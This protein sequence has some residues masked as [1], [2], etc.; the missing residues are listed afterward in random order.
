VLASLSTE[1]Y[2]VSKR[3]PRNDPRFIQVTEF[4]TDGRYVHDGVTYISGAVAHDQFGVSEV[5]P[6][7][8]RERD[9]PRLGRPYRWVCLFITDEEAARMLGL[10]PHQLRDRRGGRYFYAEPDLASTHGPVSYP[11][12]W[13]DPRDGSEWLTRAANPVTWPRL[14]RL[15]KEVTSETQADKVPG[16]VRAKQVSLLRPTKNSDRAWL[17]TVWVYHKEDSNEHAKPDY[18]VALKAAD[19]QQAIY[20][21]H[22]GKWFLSPKAFAAVIGVHISSVPTLR[23]KGIP[24]M[25]VIDKGR[26]AGSK[27]KPITHP[28]KYGPYGKILKFLGEDDAKAF[29]AARAAL[30]TVEEFRRDQKALPHEQRKVLVEDA[31]EAGDGG[32]LQLRALVKKGLHGKKGGIWSDTVILKH[33]EKV[34]GKKDFEF[35]A[36]HTVIWQKDADDYRQAGLVDPV[37]VGRTTAAELARV[38][39]SSIGWVQRMAG[40]LQPALRDKMPTRTEG[41]LLRN[42]YDKAARRTVFMRTTG[43]HYIKSEWKLIWAAKYPGKPWPLENPNGSASPGA[44]NHDEK[45]DK[46]TTTYPELGIE[47][48]WD[49]RVIRNGE[50]SVDLSRSDIQWHIFRVSAVAFPDPATVE[51]M[52]TDYPGEEDQF[53]RR[54]STY[55]LNKKLVQVGVRI[56]QRQLTRLTARNR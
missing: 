46:T 40:Q 7:Y 4:P 38:F 3:T 5:Q 11:D 55:E 27:R 20:G 33:P 1:F 8:Y 45:L 52:L 36:T 14:L 35:T 17:R 25:P 48:D 54:T 32:E 44:P 56:T 49:K 28:F 31:A 50:V 15:R 30:Q 42:Y 53:A 9:E 24:W 22:K 10:E 41:P 18:K 12:H 34:R 23:D 39:N 47:V 13:T 26:K 37:P 29:G 21:K 2:R 51:A 19:R 43:D 6:A 16:R